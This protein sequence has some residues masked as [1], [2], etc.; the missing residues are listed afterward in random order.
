[1]LMV[2]AVG[3]TIIGAGMVVLDYLEKRKYRKDSTFWWDAERMKW[4]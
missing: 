3:V 1:M 2:I 4:K